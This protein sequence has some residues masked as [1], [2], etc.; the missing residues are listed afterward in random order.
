MIFKDVTQGRVTDGEEY[1]QSYT[2]RT[3]EK[4]SLSFFLKKAT[5]SAGL[6]VCGM[7]M[8]YMDKEQI[9]LYEQLFN[10]KIFPK[11]Q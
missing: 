7:R 10:E 1:Q 6:E 2:Q 11:S 3:K 4:D 5:M 8:I 9:G